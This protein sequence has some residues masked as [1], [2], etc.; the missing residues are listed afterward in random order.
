MANVIVVPETADYFHDVSHHNLVWISKKLGTPQMKRREANYLAPF[1][2]GDNEG[3]NRL[4]HVTG[5]RDTEDSTEVVLGNSFVLPSNWT[6]IGQRRRF[7]YHPLRKFGFVEIR[8]GLLLHIGT[9]A[10]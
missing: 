5:V 4:F 6:D 7:E 2:I 10:V 8:P 3:V 9:G 1:W